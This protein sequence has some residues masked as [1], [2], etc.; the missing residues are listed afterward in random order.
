MKTVG[1]RPSFLH[2]ILRVLV[3]WGILGFI[4]LPWTTLMYVLLLPRW[5][6]QI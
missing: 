2:S 5:D 3:I 6:S 1:N 4:F